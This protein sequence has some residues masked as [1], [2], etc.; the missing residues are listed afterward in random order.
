M[1]DKPKVSRDEIFRHVSELAG[2]DEEGGIL[3]PPAD[4]KIDR[5][6]V[7]W[8]RSDRDEK[9]ELESNRNV[10]PAR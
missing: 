5:S 9:S 8:W 2:V 1:S 4:L 6:P 7:S 3:P 10:T